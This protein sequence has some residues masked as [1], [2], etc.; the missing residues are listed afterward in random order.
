MPIYAVIPKF[1]DNQTIATA[2][3]KSRADRLRARRRDFAECILGRLS[4]TRPVQVYDEDS[5]YGYVKP[6][7][8]SPRT[9]VYVRKKS[10]LNVLL[11]SAPPDVKRL[12]EDDPDVDRVINADEPVFAIPKPQAGGMG[13]SNSPWH[14][15]VVG[16]RLAHKLGFAGGGI[17]IGI[18]DTGLDANHPEFANRTNIPFAEYNPS[19]IMIQT[20]PYEGD[21]M[22]HGTHVTALATGRNV[23]VAKDAELAVARVLPDS[24]GGKATFQQVIEG[25]DWLAKYPRPDGEVGVDIM[26]LSFCTVDWAGKSVLDYSFKAIIQ[27]IRNL[28][29]EV[30]AAIGN[31]GPNTHGSPGNYSDV[32]AIGAVDHNDNIWPNSSCGTVASEGNINKPDFFAPGV[33]VYS[34]LP[35]NAYGGMSGSSMA[36]PV[37]AGVSALITQQL[38]TTLGLRKELRSRGISIS[39]GQGNQAYLRIHF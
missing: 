15:D 37:A 29:I 19:G 20:N 8:V 10:A 3:A 32:I 17:W 18:A 33:D 21:S 27:S 35:G 23:G 31:S 9:E 4:D 26:S 39:T 30:V 5:E 6:S 22:G 36:T 34:A 28:D 11:V 16:A 7:A 24:L 2:V 12:L 14:L 1:S 25:L 13:P 38:G